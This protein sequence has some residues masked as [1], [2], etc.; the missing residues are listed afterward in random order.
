MLPLGKS[1]IAPLEETLPTPM[2]GTFPVYSLNTD[3]TY[4]EMLLKS[5]QK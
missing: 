3:G 4:S 1:I 2:R 5:F